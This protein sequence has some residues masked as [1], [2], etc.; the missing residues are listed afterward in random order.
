MM[1]SDFLRLDLIVAL[2]LFSFLPVANADRALLVGINAYATE[3][4][5]PPPRCS[6]PCLVV[7]PLHGAVADVDIARSLLI[8]TLGYRA[9]DIRVITDRDATADRILTEID[10]WLVNGTKPG[11]RAYFHYSG[12]G[13]QAPDDG[14]D[15]ADGFDEAIVPVDFRFLKGG[16][17]E[18]LIRDDQ[19]QRAFSGLKG[20]RFTAVFDSCHSGT[21][22]R[23]AGLDDGAVQGRTPTALQQWLVS[24]TPATRSPAATLGTRAGESAVLDSEPGWTIWSAASA[25]QVAWDMQAPLGG[26]FTRLLAEEI[27]NGVESASTTHAAVLDRVQAA[28]KRFCT[29]LDKCHGLVPTLETPRNWLAAPLATS[30]LAQPGALS[31]STV[32]ETATAVLPAGASNGDG[33]HV[34]VTVHPGTSVPL[35]TKLQYDIV[36]DVAGQLMIFDA[37][38]SGVL[39]QIFPNRRKP[40]AR[41]TAGNPFTLPAQNHGFDLVAQEPIGRGRLIVVVSD[42][43]VDFSDLAVASRGLKEVTEPQDFLAEIAARLRKAR[44]DG[45]GG[46][47]LAAWAI[48]AVDYEVTR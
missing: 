12:H 48:G 20:R 41:V 17:V 42:G 22:T 25:N 6:K 35:G 23:A 2:A 21:V 5:D 28:S 32:L 30:L 18:N 11:E 31:A 1:T 19:L 44:P 7:G 37:E 15:E 43:S 27:R 46:V 39:R 47:K 26:V 24:Q 9:D 14:G 40:S 13:V 4:P 38:P 16:K 33:Q 36:S 3:H 45:T 8:D 29:T 10:Q 34:K